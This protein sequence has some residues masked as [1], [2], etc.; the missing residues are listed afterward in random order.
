MAFP[1]SKFFKSKKPNTSR[2][3]YDAAK[4]GRLLNDWI[5]A[6]LSADA[7]LR[8]RLGIIRDR[9]R[10]LER[11]DQWVRGFLR[12]LSNN[13]VG[14]KGVKMQMKVRDASGNMDVIANNRIEEAWKNWGRSGKPTVCGRHSWVDLQRL[15]IRGMARDGEILIRKIKNEDGL[16]LQIIE[17]DLLDER[18]HFRTG[19]GNLVRFGVEMDIYRKPVAYHL[20]TVHPGDGEFQSNDRNRVRVPAGEIYHL[21]LSDRADQTRGVPWMASC[22]ASLKML[23]GY[24]EAE[25]VAART[26]AAKMGFFTKKTPDGWTGEVDGDGNLS[27]DGSSGTIEELPTG[28]GFDSWN[29]D[30]PNSGYSDFVKSIL[31]GVASS[32]G[33]SYNTLSSDLEGVNYSSIRAGLL[34]EREAWKSLQNFLVDHFMLPLFEDWLEM[35]LLLGRVGNLPFSKFWKFNAPDFRPRRWAWVDP[36]KDME[37]AVISIRSG[38]KSHRAVIAEGGGDIYGTA[39][40][41][42]DDAELFESLGISIPGIH[43][44]PKEEVREVIDKED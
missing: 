6:P 32:L 24:Q 33:I 21:Y 27:M 26:G 22:A 16:K 5:S 15:V 3:G 30:H 43:D 17:P 2:R 31:R 39:R 37:A 42:R 11:N 41:M 4:S 19:N 14:E 7:E 9:C 40:E 25:L 44:E 12:A 10:D 35:E 34:D 36:K 8:G 28:V 1:F 20:W 18:D 29:P 38:L 13:V 23:G